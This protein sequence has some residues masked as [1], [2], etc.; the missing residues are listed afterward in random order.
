MEGT[1]PKTIQRQSS[2]L[3]VAQKATLSREKNVM[4]QRRTEGQLERRLFWNSHNS[5]SSLSD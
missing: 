2:N 3:E 5:E 4:D 1:N